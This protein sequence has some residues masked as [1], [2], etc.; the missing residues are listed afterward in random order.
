MPLRL[1]TKLKSARRQWP[2]RMIPREHAKLR[3]P[4]DSPQSR[5][6]RS[7]C[8]PI[9]LS[10]RSNGRRL[11]HNGTVD[12]GGPNGGRTWQSPRRV[13][14]H[15][16]LV[17]S[18]RPVAQSRERDFGIYAGWRWLAAAPGWRPSIMISG[19]RGHRDD[20]QRPLNPIT[21]RDRLSGSSCPGAFP[22]GFRRW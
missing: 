4:L 1:N 18:S 14:R 21:I 7:S 12:S 9:A 15:S 20:V 16:L 6:I 22:P 17:G 8:E 13:P 3:V 11:R 2:S 19:S 10:E 5:A